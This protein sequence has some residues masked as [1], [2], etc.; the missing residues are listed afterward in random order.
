MSDETKVRTPSDIKIDIKQN[1]VRRSSLSP[2]LKE[3]VIHHKLELENKRE[4]NELT[5]CCGSRFDKRVLTSLNKTFIIFIVLLFS[6]LKIMTSHDT[7][8]R[9]VY[10]NIILLILGTAINTGQDNKRK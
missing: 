10:V 7:T 2:E 6:I 3:E 5:S 4:D 8:E 1:S 9:N